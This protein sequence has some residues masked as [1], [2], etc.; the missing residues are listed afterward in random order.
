MLNQIRVKAM[1]KYLVLSLASLSLTG[2]LT[3]RAL[4][5]NV[6]LKDAAPCFSFD[7]AEIRN[8]QVQIM[9][10][11]MWELNHTEKVWD[12]SWDEWKTMSR[13][14]CLPYSGAELK[15]NALYTVYFSVDI[16]GTSKTEYQSYDSVFCLTKNQ[17]GQT[18][19]HQWPTREAPAACPA[20]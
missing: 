17:D 20:N 7:S 14:E 16:E 2:C 8:E 12:I 18:V 1:K 4:T 6:F 13:G 3:L 19:L 5:S 11:E 10:A 9:S 15:M